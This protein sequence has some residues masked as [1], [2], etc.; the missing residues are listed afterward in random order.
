MAR[1]MASY[2]PDQLVDAAVSVAGEGYDTCDLATDNGIWGN[3]TTAG[4]GGSSQSKKYCEPG[5]EVYDRSVL[6]KINKH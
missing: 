2:N 6:N 5:M 3:T 1:Q 4:S